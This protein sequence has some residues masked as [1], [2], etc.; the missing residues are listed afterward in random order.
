MIHFPLKSSGSP[1]YAGPV[2]IKFLDFWRGQNRVSVLN[3]ALAIMATAEM[4]CIGMLV[5][6]IVL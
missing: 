6:I 4:F 3:I 5:R 1:A 2:R